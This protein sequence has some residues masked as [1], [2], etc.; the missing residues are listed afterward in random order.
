MGIDL[1]L[2]PDAYDTDTREKLSWFLAHTRIDLD[3]SYHIFGQINKTY[4]RGDEVPLVCE[5]KPLPEGMKFQWYED[6]GLKTRTT[7]PYGDALTYVTAGELAKV[8]LGATGKWNKAVFKMIKA[9]PKDTLV[10]LW[11]H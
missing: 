2:C 5:P 4:G 1:T 7:D 10:V 6:E 11:W 3:R 8:Q 9:L